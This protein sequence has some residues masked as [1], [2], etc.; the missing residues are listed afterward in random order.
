MDL[1]ALGTDPGT[2]SFQRTLKVESETHRKGLSIIQGA[3]SH[4][5][6]DGGSSHTKFLRWYR[7]SCGSSEWTELLAIKIEGKKRQTTA[8]SEWSVENGDRRGGKDASLKRT[9]FSAMGRSHRV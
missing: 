1:L 2:S 4:V 3:Y 8:R 6:S 5:L 7:S 9:S